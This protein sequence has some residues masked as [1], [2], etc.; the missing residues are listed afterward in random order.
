MHENVV[1]FRNFIRK[2]TSFQRHMANS[3]RDKGP[4]R[5]L[6]LR[7][8]LQKKD[9]WEQSS[10][11]EVTVMGWSPTTRNYFMTNETNNNDKSQQTQASKDQNQPKT[12]QQTGQQQGQ[13]AEQGKT[14]EVTPNTGAKPN[15]GDKVTANKDADQ[16]K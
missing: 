1:G 4:F 8:G 10:R 5:A 6:W 11:G 2:D 16:K 3:K 13:H 7:Q 14:G 12:G 15:Q 9:A